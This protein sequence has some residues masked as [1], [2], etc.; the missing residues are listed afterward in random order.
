MRSFL[1]HALVLL[2]VTTALAA[3]PLLPGKSDVLFTD[4]RG[5]ADK[6]IRV[7]LF[8]PAH[9]QPTSPIV[10]V[11][12]GTLRNG[13]TYR[14]PWIALAEPAGA[15]VVVPEFSREY[16]GDSG[17]YQFGNMRT[18]SGEPIDE[19]KWTFAAIEHLFD[20]LKERSG[21][22]RE[23]YFMFGHSAGAQFVHRMVLFQADN[24]IALAV[25]A[26]AGSYTFPDFTIK[27]PYGLKESPITES[28]LKSALQTPMLVLLG[29][30]DTDTNDQYLPKSSEAMTQGPMRLARG[31]NFYQSAEAAANRLKV[32]LKW[33]KIV[34][35]G[36]GHDN[37]LMA[38]VAARAMFAKP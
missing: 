29:E 35:P 8:R 7:W 9:F 22:R 26:N 2:L 13:E 5:N 32:P 23:N 14:E 24:R 3:D 12:H 10:F 37:A 21:S 19:S 4:A 28:K 20:H 17:A 1:P 38:P 27:F 36:V 16:Y 18:K 15:L 34:V 6:P 30:N 25:T 33:T 31:Q 11:M